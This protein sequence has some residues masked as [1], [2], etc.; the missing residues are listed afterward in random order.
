MKRPPLDHL[1]G[2]GIPPQGPH[3][4]PPVKD[5]TRERYGG[6]DGRRV[7]YVMCAEVVRIVPNCGRDGPRVKS[8]RWG[9]FVAG[10]GFRGAERQARRR[11][12][13]MTRGVTRSIQ[14]V[15]SSGWN[16]MV[17]L[18]YLSIRRSA[19]GPAALLDGQKPPY[20]SALQVVKGTQE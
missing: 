3:P 9:R 17:V 1:C 4:P 6:S 18:R 2:V 15:R 16:I 11:G 19:H 10:G 5:L 20:Q 12:R 8:C 14:E 7:R 13:R